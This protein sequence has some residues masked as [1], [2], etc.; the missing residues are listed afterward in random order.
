LTSA[1]GGSGWQTSNSG[2]L[3]RG[4]N[5]RYPLSGREGGPQTGSEQCGEI[6]FL[7]WELN[8]GSSEKYPSQYT[9]YAIQCP[10]NVSIKYKIVMLK[11]NETVPKKRYEETVMQGNDTEAIFHK[12]L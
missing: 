3:N 5:P 8:P 7:G 1:P 12:K 4:K 10:I 9:R 6:S 2:H 11:I